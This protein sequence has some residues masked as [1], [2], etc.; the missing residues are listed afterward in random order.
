MT[1]P[2]EPDTSYPVRHVVSVGC[3]HVWQD[4]THK[5]PNMFLYA[6]RARSEQ[7]WASYSPENPEPGGFFGS[8][9]QRWL[10][11]LTPA[12]LCDLYAARDRA[13]H[14]RKENP[15]ADL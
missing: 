14:E 6:R 11:E 9:V 10:D 1:T 15:D 8:E 13:Y 4:T 7:W 5:T 12:Q 2:P 3:V